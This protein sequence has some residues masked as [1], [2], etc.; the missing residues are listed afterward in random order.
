MSVQCP[1]C[2]AVFGGSAEKL[3]PAEKTWCGA[4][5][6]LHAPGKHTRPMP[7]T[8]SQRAVNDP[9]PDSFD[10]EPTPTAP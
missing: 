4:C 2:G 9:E 10:D 1:A 7:I 8:P 3:P 5:G 6:V